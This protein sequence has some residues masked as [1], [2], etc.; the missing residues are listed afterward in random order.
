[1]GSNVKKGQLLLV[2]DE[3]PFKVALEQAKAQLSAAAASLEKAQSSKAVEVA[4][5]T[6]AHGS[7]PDAAG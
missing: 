3:K 2:I 6:M 4:K 1:M 5:A 7:G